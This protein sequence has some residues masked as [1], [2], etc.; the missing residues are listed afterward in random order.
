MTSINGSEPFC[1]VVAET[2][3]ETFGRGR[4]GA[5]NSDCAPS[6]TFTVPTPELP[7]FPDPLL[8]LSGLGEICAS[9]EHTTNQVLPSA[10]HSRDCD[11]TPQPAD[12]DELRRQG[13]P[14]SFG[15]E[16]LD[17]GTI[18]NGPTRTSGHSITSTLD[19]LGL[20]YPGKEG[21]ADCGK[22]KK[23]GR[24]FLIRWTGIEKTVSISRRASSLLCGST[25]T[26]AKF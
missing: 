5:I 1:N 16:L 14:K 2:E 24:R 13:R 8:E 10:S 21:D 15:K 4:T 12:C 9:G 3:R 23:R 22:K 7:A 6:V 18:D 17:V 20:L 19:D 25:N 11:W 26:T